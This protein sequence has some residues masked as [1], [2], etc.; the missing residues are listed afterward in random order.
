MS[1]EE[2]SLAAEIFGKVALK[3]LGTVHEN[4][5]LYKAGWLGARPPFEIM[6]VTGAR[7]RVAQSGPREGQLC[8]KV[9]ATERT[10]Y[11]TSKEMK[12][13]EKKLK[14]AKQ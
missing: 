4:F 3:K 9:P 13:L 11:I 12:A 5:R 10:V 7:F 1:I 8:I 14:G 2:H 6:E